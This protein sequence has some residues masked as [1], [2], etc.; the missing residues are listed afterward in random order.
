MPFVSLI[1]VFTSSSPLTPFEFTS[2]VSEMN[3]TSVFK[4]L[5]VLIFTSK[6]AL[7][8]VRFNEFTFWEEKLIAMSGLT[9]PTILISERIKIIYFSNI[10]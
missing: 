3:I 1:A 5:I 2:L 10:N 7:E 4:F 8:P 9:A 6:L